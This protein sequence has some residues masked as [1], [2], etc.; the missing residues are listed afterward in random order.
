M[1]DGGN[2]TITIVDDVVRSREPRPG[3][4]VVLRAGQ[5]DDRVHFFEGKSLRFGRSSELAIEDPG[6]SSDHATIECLGAAGFRITD[7]ASKNGTFVNSD[8]VRA[9]SALVDGPSAVVRMGMT[10]LLLSSDLGHYE[11]KFIRTEGDE[12]IGAATATIYA[13]LGK[14]AR[15]GANTL[16]QGETGTGK[17]NAARAFHAESGRRGKLLS[18]NCAN[19]VGSIAEAQLFGARRGVAS[20]VEAQVGLFRA[21]DRGTVFLDEIGELALDLQAKLLSVVQDKVVTPL[22]ATAAEKVDFRLI[23]ATHRDLPQMVA[24]GRFREDLYMRI[25]EKTVC[26]PPLRERREEIPHLIALSLAGTAL[27][28]T[29]QLVETCML[30]RW[31]G[32]VRDL[33]RALTEAKLNAEAESVLSVAHLPAWARRGAAVPAVVQEEAPRHL[34]RADDDNAPSKRE[35][36]ETVKRYYATYRNAK[37]AAD[38]AGVARTTAHRWLKQDGLIEEDE[39]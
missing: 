29:A 20:G 6:M 2:R 1:S 13:E 17:G 10:V 38:L 11:L 34:S 7:R 31:P 28:P 22:G 5:P 37:K 23:C 21:A 24:E 9:T 14:A 16:V 12:V 27:R 19:V 25:A 39:G 26:L 32:N 15:A 8:C 18:L 36:R 30:Q 35:L 4:M 3:V 33:T